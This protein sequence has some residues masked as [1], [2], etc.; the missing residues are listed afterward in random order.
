MLKQRQLFS[1][2]AYNWPEFAAIRDNSPESKYSY[3]LQQRMHD[4]LQRQPLAPV[5]VDR[6]SVKHARRRDGEDQ[7]RHGV[8]R[9]RAPLQHGSIRVSSAAPR[10]KDA[11]ASG[12]V[13][14]YTGAPSSFALSTMILHPTL[15]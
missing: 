1:Q 8:R 15:E 6:Q 10:E 11:F 5:V 12:R 9:R 2:N 14:R 7:Q 13:T 4:G 3:L